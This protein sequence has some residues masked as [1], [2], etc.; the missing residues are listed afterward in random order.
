MPFPEII[1]TDPFTGMDFTAY[2]VDNYTL[3]A[4]HPLTGEKIRLHYN[5][6]KNTYMIPAHSISHIETLTYSQASRELETS[7]Q[8]VSAACKSGKIPCKI[9]PNGSKMILKKDIEQYAKTRKVGRP[10]KNDRT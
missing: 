5:A 4:I 3:L 6:E 9:L 7:L 8:R 1:L 10:R 2:R